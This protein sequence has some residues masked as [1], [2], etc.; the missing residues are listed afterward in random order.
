MYEIEGKVRRL[1]ELD[2]VITEGIK[3][4]D[5]TRIVGNIEEYIN[6]KREIKLFSASNPLINIPELKDT[7]LQR[8]I[9]KLTAGER[10]EKNESIF[11]WNLLEAIEDDLDFD[12][13]EEIAQEIFF[14]SFSHYDYVRGIFEIGSLVLNFKQ[15]PTFLKD[16]INEAKQCYAFQQYLAVCSL[17]RSILEIA[18]KDIC[19][20][21]GFIESDI[22]YFSFSKNI[23]K[24]SS[25][26]IEKNLRALYS[27]ASNVIHPKTEITSTHA[28][29][30][31]ALTIRNVQ[32]LYLSNNLQN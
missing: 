25:G 8:I 13:M 31:F 21:R 4:S 20:K 24:I 9:Q 16:Y 18:A 15:L 30:I 14:P 32:D 22:A 17:C 1:L 12:E 7:K 19:D 6:L 26:E 28:K 23:Q 27:N 29:E 10:L 5:K 2:K 11:F 3:D